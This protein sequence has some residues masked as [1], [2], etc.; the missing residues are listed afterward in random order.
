[1]AQEVKRAA[2]QK[3]DPGKSFLVRGSTL[4]RL[5]DAVQPIRAGKGLKEFQTALGT[6][7]MLDVE[8]GATPCAFGYVYSDA[9]D[10][11]LQGG[12]VTGGET[13]TTVPAITLDME[14]ADY[15]YLWLEVDYTP[16]VADDVLLPGV[17]NLT[18]VTTGDG[19]TMPG[20]TVPTIAAPTGKMHIALGYYLNGK[21]L[22]SGCGNVT[23]GHCPG[24]PNYVRA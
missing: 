19:P 4:N 3:F 17:E 11:K 13:N 1:M 24:Y 21:F 15:T 22:P 23:I 5:L 2:V 16:N 10:M 9:G 12:V 18:G 7:F 8:V 20:N 6:V 14:S